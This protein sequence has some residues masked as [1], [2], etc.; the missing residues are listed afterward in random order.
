MPQQWLTRMIFNWDS[1]HGCPWITCEIFIFMFFFN[2][3][4]GYSMM[5]FINHSTNSLQNILS[6]EK[7]LLYSVYPHV[8]KNFTESQRSIYAQ[9]H[10]WGKSPVAIESG[11]LN[12]LPKEKNTLFLW[13]RWYWRQ[14]HLV[15]FC[16]LY[17]HLRNILFGKLSV[18]S[19][20][21]FWTDVYKPHDLCFSRGTCFG[22][23]YLT[24]LERRQ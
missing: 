5:I 4:T 12:G 3:K 16:V 15:F 20:E 1:L 22:R 9:L 13:F 23:F 10:Q 24:S 18:M 21:S 17:D 7:Q 8:R 19:V 6:H 11:K 14:R 2:V